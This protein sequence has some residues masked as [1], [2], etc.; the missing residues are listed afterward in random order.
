MHRI[1]PETNK[2]TLGLSDQT[3]SPLHML[4]LVQ[5]LY[6]EEYTK[7]ELELFSVFIV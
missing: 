2:G 1:L 3:D 4:K 6:G 5:M 7:K